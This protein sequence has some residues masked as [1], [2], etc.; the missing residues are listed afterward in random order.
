MRRGTSDRTV[1]NYEVLHRLERIADPA[2]QTNG[3]R[4]HDL[5]DALVAAGMLADDRC[6]VFSTEGLRPELL[7]DRKK[8]RKAEQRAKL[9]DERLDRGRPQIRRS[10]TPTRDKASLSAPTS[11]AS[12]ETGGSRSGSGRPPPGADFGNDD[13]RGVGAAN[14]DFVHPPRASI[15]G[16][17]GSVTTTSNSTRPMASSACTRRC[18]R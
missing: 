8:R 3:R 16:R 15:P 17:S 6:D 14:A 18:W 11:K 12:A 5:E 4:V 2:C 1:P 7:H 9:A 10:S 13:P